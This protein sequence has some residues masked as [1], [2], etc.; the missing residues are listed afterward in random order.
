MCSM[1]I[2][3][4]IFSFFWFCIMRMISQ[5]SFMTH[6]FFLKIDMCV[7]ESELLLAF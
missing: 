7:K 3:R 5:D 1:V 6:L 2:R 4:L